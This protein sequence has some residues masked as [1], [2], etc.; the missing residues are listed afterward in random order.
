MPVDD[1]NTQHNEDPF[2]KCT[3]CSQLINV[4]LLRGHLQNCVFGSELPDSVYLNG[5]TMSTIV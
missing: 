5:G 4:R 2:E 1:N 3:A